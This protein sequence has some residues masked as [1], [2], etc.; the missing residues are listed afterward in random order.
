MSS[1][2]ASLT[3]S[4]SCIVE[5]NISNLERLLRLL[6]EA[7]NEYYNLGLHLKLRPH[8]LKTIEHDYS[9]TKRRFTE[10]LMEWLKMINPQPSWKGLIH[11]LAL[12]G[13]KDMA[14]EISK[15]CGMPFPGIVIVS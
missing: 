12:I 11:A 7:Q 8:I 6:G 1:I 15:Q 4:N 9:S 14:M 5:L 3:L 2:I 13:R 10:T